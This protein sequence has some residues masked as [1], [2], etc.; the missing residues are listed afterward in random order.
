MTKEDFKFA[1]DLLW[2]DNVSHNITTNSETSHLLAEELRKAGVEV[3]SFGKKH[4]SRNKFILFTIRAYRVKGLETK[5]VTR[6]HA[7]AW[8]KSKSM[9]LGTLTKAPDEAFGEV[10]LEEVEEMLWWN[11]AFSLAY[12]LGAPLEKVGEAV[13]RYKGAHIAPKFG[14]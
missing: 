4:R 7:E 3:V 9:T 8:H 12:R 11:Q 1:K 6:E 14:I 13:L 5:F 2:D 10:Q